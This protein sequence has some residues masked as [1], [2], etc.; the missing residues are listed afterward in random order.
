MA[1]YFIVSGSVKVS[2]EW[3]FYRKWTHPYF[4][5]PADVYGMF[6]YISQKLMTFRTGLYTSGNMMNPSSSIYGRLKIN[7]SFLVCGVCFPWSNVIKVTNPQAF[8]LPFHFT[9]KI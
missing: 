7:Y 1:R 9:E 8:S 6:I 2:D 4:T 3:R 5:E